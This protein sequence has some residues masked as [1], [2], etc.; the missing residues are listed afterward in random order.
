[1]ALLNRPLS[2]NDAAIQRLPQVAVNPELDIPPSDDEV[3]KA[4]KQ[5]SCGKDPGPD[6]IPAERVQVRSPRSC[7][8]VNRTV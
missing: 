1:M 6:A 5:M 7:Y 4:I 3:A 8:K 2:I